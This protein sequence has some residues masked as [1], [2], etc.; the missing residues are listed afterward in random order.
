MSAKIIITMSEDGKR[1]HTEVKGSMA[2]VAT[3]LLTSIDHKP[4][5]AAAMLIAVETYIRRD[6]NKENPL[7]AAF[8]TNRKTNYHA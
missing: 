6:E 7:V 4:E 8:N 2:D 5:F 1:C 3:L